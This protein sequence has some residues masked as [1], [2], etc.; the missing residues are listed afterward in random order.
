[1][2]IN[3]LAE[4]FNTAINA[5]NVLIGSY[6][7]NVQNYPRRIDSHEVPMIYFFPAY[8]KN[9]PYLRFLGNPKVSEF[10]EFIKKHADIKFEIGVDLAQQELFQEMRIKQ[11]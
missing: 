2:K 7:V 10:A 9:P 3:E 4:K 8:H 11:M 5:K 6:D 1:M